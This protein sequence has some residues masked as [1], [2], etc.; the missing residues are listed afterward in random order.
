MVKQ[1]G[2]AVRKYVRLISISEDNVQCPT[3]TAAAGAGAAVMI[4]FLPLL[5]SHCL[6]RVTRWTPTDYSLLNIFRGCS[7]FYF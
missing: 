2:E 1:H 3:A 5:N 7:L 4:F 6:P